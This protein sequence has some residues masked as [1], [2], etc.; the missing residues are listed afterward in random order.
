[1]DAELTVKRLRR[2]SRDL[3]LGDDLGRAVIQDAIAFIRNQTRPLTLDECRD[4][5]NANKYSF[6]TGWREDSPWEIEGVEQAHRGN[7]EPL[8]YDGHERLTLFEA[9]CLARGF[10]ARGGAA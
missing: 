4:V 8:L 1:M 6:Y 10:M 5:L 7:D 2:L 3:R 9:T